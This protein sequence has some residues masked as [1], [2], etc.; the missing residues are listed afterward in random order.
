MNSLCSISHL[1]PSLDTTES[2]MTVS[3]TLTAVVSV[4]TA[5]KAMVSAIDVTM[6]EFF[7][8]N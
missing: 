7:F 1:C 6:V 4:M 2:N 5:S 3:P 8:I